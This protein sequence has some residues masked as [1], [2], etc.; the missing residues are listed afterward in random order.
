VT[1]TYNPTTGRVT[2]NAS[3]LTTGATY[4]I[5]V[6]YDPGSLVGQ[7]VGSSKPTSVYTFLTYINGTVVLTSQDAVNVKFKQ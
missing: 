7:T 2:F 6:K 3:G 1:G 5:S 4:Y